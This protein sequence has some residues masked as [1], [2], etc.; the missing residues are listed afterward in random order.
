M[1]T[2]EIKTL[3]AGAGAFVRR[4][5]DD[6]EEGAGFAPPTQS[7]GLTRAGGTVRRAGTMVRSPL[8]SR[9]ERGDKGHHDGELPASE[10]FF[11]ILSSVTPQIYREQE[12]IADF[13]QIHEQT[14][15]FAD[16]MELEAYFRR[17]ASRFA[18]A[19]GG[20]VGK[21]ARGAM[22][23]IFG[24]LVGELRIWIDTALAKDQLQIVGIMVNLERFI[25]DAGERGNSYVSR[26]LQKQYQRLTG[27]Y[28]RNVDEYI[29]AIEQTKLTTKKAE[30]RRA[31]HQVLSG[32]CKPH[33]KSADWCRR[34]RGPC[35][36]RCCV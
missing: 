20:L 1:H 34:P 12:F 26:L 15:T 16:Y 2:K 7:T 23:L 31:L 9:K 29:K 11:H 10:V 36:R 25:A 18:S 14:I 4:E 17:Q 8:E 28:N 5:K 19:G 22:D 13:L 27:L 21:L 35:E 30:R 3:L 33:R 6:G 24:F 32:L